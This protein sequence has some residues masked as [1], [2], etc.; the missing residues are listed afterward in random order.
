MPATGR[1]E[2][3]GRAPAFGRLPRH[4]L[5]EIMNT[6]LYGDRTGIVWRHLPHDLPN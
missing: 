5:R 3:S 2:R 1:F 4:D 6:N